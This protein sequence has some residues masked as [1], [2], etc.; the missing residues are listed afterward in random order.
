MSV[1]IRLAF[2]PLAGMILCVGVAGSGLLVPGY[3]QVRQTVSEIG[4]MG[5]PA[6]IPFAAMLCTVAACLFVFATGLKETSRDAGHSTLTAY[7]VGIMGISAAGVGIFAYPHPLHN[8][9]G[10][11]ELIGYQAPLALGL[12]WRRKTT[13]FVVTFSWSMYVLMV[14]AIGAN[15]SV[16]NRGGSL[17]QYERPVYGLVQRALFAVWFLWCAGVG[18]I[19]SSEPRGKMRH[20]Q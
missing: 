12:T 14:L 5:S 18:L 10:M 9:F 16:L 20:S 7:L 2:G 13:P 3:S 11:S 1:R 15:L 8:A 4:E 19:L 17:W 6:R